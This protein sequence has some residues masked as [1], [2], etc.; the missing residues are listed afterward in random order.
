VAI[1]IVI[2]DNYVELLGSWPCRARTRVEIRNEMQIARLA[3]TLTIIRVV[4]PVESR[5]RLAW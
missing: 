5:V 2:A 4:S 3:A 1:A